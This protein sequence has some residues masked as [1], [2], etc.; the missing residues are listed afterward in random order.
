MPCFVADQFRSC[1]Q[2]L[3][4][5]RVN[6]FNHGFLGWHEGSEETQGNLS[7]FRQI[8][9]ALSLSS[10]FEFLL[11]YSFHQLE[12]AALS[13]VDVEE[14][15]VNFVFVEGDDVGEEL[16]NVEHRPDLVEV[17]QREKFYVDVK[18]IQVFGPLSCHVLL[19]DASLSV[20]ICKQE[21]SL[22]IGLFLHHLEFLVANPESFKQRSS[23]GTAA[24]AAAAL[25]L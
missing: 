17:R 21:D 20:V 19:G 6:L 18:A 25:E 3:V 1:L 16:A 10:L 14:T 22:C 7:I 13:L 4:I 12:K 2:R 15:V 23:R 9:H 8:K 5:D 24:V 11:P